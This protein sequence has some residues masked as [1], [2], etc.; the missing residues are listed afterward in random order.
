MKKQMKISTKLSILFTILTLAVAILFYFLLPSLLNYPPD[1]INTEFDKEVSK[2]YYIFQYTIAIAVIIV[3]FN[4]YFK[5]SLRGLDKWVETKD[6]NKI[7]E[8]RKTCFQY[9]F[10]L[11]LTIEILPLVIVL[12]T[13]A[14]TGSHPRNIT[15]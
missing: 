10:K 5:I 1:T 6:K 4:I 9:P 14:N 13:L 3:F 11:F 12:A 8:I 7:P 15:F 2:L